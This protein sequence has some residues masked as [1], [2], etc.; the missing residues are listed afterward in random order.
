MR[1]PQNTLYGRNTTGGAVNFVSRKPDPNE[2]TNGNI[3]ATYGNYNQLGL[4]GAF[5]AAMS[6]TS[7]FR[8]A[9]QYQGRDG[10][11]DNRT[12]GNEDTEV[13]KFAAR[14]MALFQPTDTLEILLRAHG[15]QIDGT[16]VM[17]KSI[18][19]RDPAN[20][21]GP[22]TNTSVVVGFSCMNRIGLGGNCV[23]Q[24][25]FRDTNDNTENFANLDE[26]IE[27][28]DAFGASAHVTW[29]AENF[30]LT[31]ITAYETN[32]FERQEDSDASPATNFHFNQDS[33]ADQYSQEFRLASPDDLSTRWI[34]GV[35]GF[36]EDTRGDTGPIQAQGAMAMVN[37]TR[38]EMES[39]VYSAYGEIEH[40]FNDRVTGILGLRYTYDDRTGR[41]RTITRFCTQVCASLTPEDGQDTM[42]FDRLRS[43]PATMGLNI[44]DSLGESWTQWGGKI[45]LEVVAD[46]DT[47]VY[48]HYSRGFKGGNFSAAPLQAIAGAISG[49]N[50]HTDP[51]E[52]EYVNAYEIG[53]KSTL[54]D[55]AMTA[56]VALFFNDYTDQQVLRLTNSPGFGLA[57][58]LVNIEGSEIFGIEFDSQIAAGDGWFIDVN[59]GLMDTEVQEFIDDDGNNFEG[60]QLANAPRVTGNIRVRKEFQLSNGNVFSLAADTQYA[61]ERQF[62]LSND[63][64]LRDDAYT[65]VNFQASYEFGEGRKYRVLAWG[66][67]ITD[68]LYFQNKSDFSS[69]GFIQAIVNQPPTYGLT[70]VANF[71]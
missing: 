48:G 5:G 68:E 43:I 63:P 7:A 61:S 12:N 70:F 46:E 71:D 26:P 16:N 25:G 20:P 8:A 35:Y 28:V 53:V 31:S 69:R 41:N 54:L 33:E 57:A 34:A 40:D 39:E 4:E 64:L 65:L 3:S 37:M 22:N 44:D 49:D 51:V 47:L 59:I 42:T 24:N 2:G 32:E 11:N 55:G 36:W 45:G 23:D 29:D 10:Y 67:N 9:F 14:V 15:E 17:W 52:P 62:D 21:A 6:E 38:L 50:A 60:N 19:T 30:T 27:K 58:A 13:E 66:K 18:G 1:G 56:N